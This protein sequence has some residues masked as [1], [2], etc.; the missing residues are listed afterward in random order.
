MEV[1]MGVEAGD[2]VVVT[3]WTGAEVG[4]VAGLATLDGGTSGDPSSGGVA[5]GALQATRNSSVTYSAEI[6]IG[7][8]NVM[9]VTNVT[10]CK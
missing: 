2:G 7:R 5:W 3:A 1:G 6:R 10:D 8:I 4:E 9:A